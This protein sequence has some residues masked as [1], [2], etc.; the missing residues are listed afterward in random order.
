MPLLGRATPRNGDEEAKS[1]AGASPMS[2]AQ[3]DTPRP[4]TRHTASGLILG[5][6]WPGL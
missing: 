1:D 4:C 2:P 6:G 3:S 5:I